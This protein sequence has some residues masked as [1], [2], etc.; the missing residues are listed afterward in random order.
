MVIG[1]VIIIAIILMSRCGGDDSTGPGEGPTANPDFMVGDWLA[2]S[3]LLTSKANPEVSVDLTTLGAVVQSF[4]STLGTLYGHR[5]RVRPILE[6][7]RHS[8]GGRPDRD[9]YEEPA[10]A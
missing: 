9:L 8:N 1:A 5:G 4:R 2:T 6:R 3:M 7:V 10:D